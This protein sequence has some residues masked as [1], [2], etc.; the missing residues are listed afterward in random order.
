MTPQRA[1]EIIQAAYDACTCGPWCDWL[2][3]VMQPGEK[4]EVKQVWET[5]PG[6]TCFV[7]AIY[8][9]AREDQPTWNIN[10]RR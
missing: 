10:T 9:I 3:R 5:M 4:E 7:D 2:D 8:R 1:R 6:D